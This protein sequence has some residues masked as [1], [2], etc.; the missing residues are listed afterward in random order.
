MCGICGILLADHGANAAPQILEA[1]NF[2]QHRGQDAAG[3]VTCGPRGRLYQ[4]KGNGMIRDVFN[5]KRLLGLIGNMG[6]GHC[7]FFFSFIFKR[8]CIRFGFRRLSPRTR[9]DYFKNV[10]FFLSENISEVRKTCRLRTRRLTITCS[11]ISDEWEFRQFRSAAV[12]RKLALWYYSLAC[13]YV[14]YYLLNA[15]ILTHTSTE[16]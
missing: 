9:N 8:V 15:C 1:M 13:M 6:V 10:F 16:R 11:T 12:L 4:C 2:L 14:S 3:I 7:K 5:E